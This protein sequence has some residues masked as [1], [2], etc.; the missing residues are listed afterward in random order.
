MTADELK[1]FLEENKVDIQNAVKA[2]VI[3]G[4]IENHRW[5]IS[6]A[7]TKVVEEF[8]AAE[9]VPEIKKYLTDQKGPILE[10]AITA[11][12]GIGEA[13]SKAIVERTT[14]RLNPDGYE[15]RQVLEALFK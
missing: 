9:I 4:L 15:F 8:I 1:T 12:A 6:G 5:E 10:A 3:S 2:K 13:L 7:I 11:T 14:K